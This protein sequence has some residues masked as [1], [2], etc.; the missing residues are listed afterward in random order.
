MNTIFIRLQAAA[1]IFS[2]FNAA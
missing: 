1:Y 2:P